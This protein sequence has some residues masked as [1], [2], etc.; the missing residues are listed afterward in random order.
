LDL[1]AELL[2]AMT[3]ATTATGTEA[4]PFRLPQPESNSA[5]ELTLAPTV[6]Y[7]IDRLIPAISRTNSGG[8]A[9]HP[10]L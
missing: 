4:C 6:A 5:I 8:D 2:F 10:I 3:F 9:E 7:P 1:S